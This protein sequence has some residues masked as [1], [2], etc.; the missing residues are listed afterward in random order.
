ML[1]ALLS[2][3]PA[4]PCREP[5]LNRTHIQIL[6]LD[7]CLW[8]PRPRGG[9]QGPS[10]GAHRACP[11][12]LQKPRWGSS[13]QGFGFASSQE[14]PPHTWACT[15][16]GTPSLTKPFPG[17]PTPVLMQTPLPRPPGLS[18]S[19][20]SPGTTETLTRPLML[21]LRA[22]VLLSG[23]GHFPWP[24]V[25]CPALPLTQPGHALSRRARGRRGR[26]HPATCATLPLR[27]QTRVT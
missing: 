20:S 18:H 16:E 23:F 2:V 6:S 13:G 8:G 22:C 27:P 1:T 11:R 19:G 12:G 26:S 10:W 9:A 4:T 7:R 5:S 24:R 14:S 17:A 3:R 15:A 25:T 21:R